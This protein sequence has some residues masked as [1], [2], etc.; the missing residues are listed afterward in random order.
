MFVYYALP[1]FTNVYTMKHLISDVYVKVYLVVN[2]KR[3]KKKKSNRREINNPVW[4][5]ALSFSLPSAN[6][7]EASIE[8]T[9]NESSVR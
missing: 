2:G 1:L 5:E 9:M 4:N 6:L 3:V 7:Q 8:V